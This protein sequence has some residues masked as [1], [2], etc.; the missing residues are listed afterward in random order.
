MIDE[1]LPVSIPYADL[2]MDSTLNPPTRIL[3]VDD[4]PDNLDLLE[5]LLGRQNYEVSRAENGMAALKQVAMHPPDLI[6]L[7]IMMPEMDGYAVCTTLKS[8]PKTCMIPVIFI[9]ALTD[10]ADKVKAFQVGGMDYITKPFQMKEILAR[11]S[12]HLTIRRLQQDLATQNTALQAEIEARKEIESELRQKRDRLEQALSDLN[13]AQVQMIQTEKMSSLGQLVAGI[14]HEIN[15]PINFIQ[16]NLLHTANY[17]TQILNLL[18]HYQKNYPQ[19]PAELQSLAT[20]IDLEFLRADLPKILASMEA[21]TNRIVAIVQSLQVFSRMDEADLQIIDLHD[22]IKSALLLL[23]HRFTEKVTRAAIHLHQNY[24][25]LPKVE[26]HAGQLNQVFMHLLS[27]AVDAID[28]AWAKYPAPQTQ[29][30]LQPPSITI[31]T[32]SLGND[33]ISVTIQDSGLGIPETVRS[34]IFDPFFTTKPIGYGT[35][36]GLSTS[37]QIIQV[38][39]GGQLRESRQNG[40]TQFIVEIP[41]RQR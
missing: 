10:A 2:D 7:D 18:Q 32:E 19:P 29:D 22:G 31:T 37:Y 28:D 20:E 24:S 21:G 1:C 8:D 5:A 40:Y 23:Q 6:L 4:H 3:V 15:N 35:G 36:L 38:Q 12:H 16:G 27:N 34:R 33:R 17:T 41:L 25:P 13:R 14:T 11:V 26:C 30:T 39:H 9:S